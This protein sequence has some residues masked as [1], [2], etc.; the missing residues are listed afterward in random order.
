MEKSW[1]SFLKNRQPIKYLKSIIS[2]YMQRETEPTFEKKKP[3]VLK[4]SADGI[5]SAYLYKK[6]WTMKQLEEYRN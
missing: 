5:S 1:I 3:H 4:M 2:R 6:K